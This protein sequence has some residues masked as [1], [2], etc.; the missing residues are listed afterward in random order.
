MHVPY[1]DSKL[2]RLLQDSLGGN[3]R[4]LM[5]ACAS[6]SDVDFV[7][8]LN[9]LN[10]ANRAKNIKNKATFLQC[11]GLCLILQIK[12]SSELRGRIAAL[13]AE[14]NEY[15]QGKKL[16]GEDGQEIVNDQYL[17]NVS[18]Q[19]E[20]NRLRTRIKALDETIDI[21]RTRSIQLQQNLEMAKL[22]ELG[23][24]QEGGDNPSSNGE[25]A[26]KG[27]SITSAIRG[28]IEELEGLRVQ[29]IE[30]RSTNEEL[31]KQNQ[32]YRSHAAESGNSVPTSPCM[33][34][35]TTA[36]NN[37]T[38]S[39]IKAAKREIRQQK[40]LAAMQANGEESSNT[41]IL[42]E[43]EYEEALEEDDMEDAADEEEDEEDEAVELVI[44]KE[45]DQLCNDLASL[46]EDIS[47]KEML[48]AEIQ[49]KDRRLKQMQQ[50]Y[51][52]KMIEL[53]E[54]I[55]NIA[56]ERDKII[57]D[58]TSK[59]G[60]KQSEEKVKQVKDDY[61]K[62]IGSLK[63][64]FKKYK[65]IE[66]EH[67]RMQM[68]QN[69]QMQD[70][71]RIQNEILEM[72]RNKVEL[73]RKLKEENKKA[74]EAERDNIKRLAGMEKQKESKVHKIRQ[75]QQQEN[76]IR[77]LKAQAAQK[78]EAIKRKTEECQR[79]REK[80]RQTEGIGGARRVNLNQTTTISHPMNTTMPQQNF[81]NC[82]SSSCQKAVF[83][84]GKNAELDQTQRQTISKME[85][86]MDRQVKERQ[87]LQEELLK[88]DSTPCSTNDE[89][90]C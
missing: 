75:I 78:A 61:E 80:Q 47:I 7:E 49:Q 51:E 44:S 43:E 40:K 65:S 15:K 63:V 24:A 11:Y 54:R 2:T 27:S 5:I 20:N 32:R 41:H 77:Q 42:I 81:C 13:E 16:T 6:P 21:L 19:H 85:E 88:L 84:H 28:Y 52:R 83:D 23:T 31:R 55:S 59:A 39:L 74:R 14:L 76:Q 10:Y 46:Q 18:L 53:T 64:E 38:T 4:T 3:S 82:F 36:A 60:G 71:Q 12:F 90:Q 69:R 67:Q 35:S 26:E 86:E 89:K 30:A 33:I 48:V 68:Q 62:K 9:T 25:G 37:N 66:K 50:D 34:N 45:R 79:L 73:M 58:I 87:L 56:A 17:E 70:M 57:A 22:G 8:T 72:K 1:R 29:L